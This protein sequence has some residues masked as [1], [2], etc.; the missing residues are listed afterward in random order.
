MGRWVGKTALQPLFCGKCISKSLENNGSLFLFQQNNPREKVRKCLQCLFVE[1]CC[2]CQYTIG[3]LVLLYFYFKFLSL[4]HDQSIFI[5]ISF[6]R[7]YIICWFF[8]YLSVCKLEVRVAQK[9][10]QEFSH[11][12]SLMWAANKP[13]IFYR[14]CIPLMPMIC[15][16]KFSVVIQSS[17]HSQKTLSVCCF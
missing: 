1:T 10:Q 13:I 7:F 6:Q 5:F 12:T 4:M 16:W 17:L 2:P 3:L 14:N 9:L 8:T 15:L 11:P